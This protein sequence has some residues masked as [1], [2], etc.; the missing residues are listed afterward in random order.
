MIL[1]YRNGASGLIGKFLLLSL[2]LWPVHL[3][4]QSA[5]K[6]AMSALMAPQPLPD[7]WLGRANAPVTLIEYASLNC[8]HCARFHKDVLPTLKTKYIDAGKLR[9]A[10]RDFPT[11]PFS[12]PNDIALQAA[13]IARCAGPRRSEIIDVLFANQ[14]GW[15]NEKEPARMIE[16]VQSAGLTRSEI[17]SCLKERVL[18]D[19]IKTGKDMTRPFLIYVV[20]S[21]FVNGIRYELTLPADAIEKALPKR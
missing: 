7:V 14:A 4:A 13:V 20:P 15:V 17:A 12:N 5:D 9:F 1:R 19:G 16:V 11:N 21:F 6:A 2:L 3:F 10:M 8:P 18:T